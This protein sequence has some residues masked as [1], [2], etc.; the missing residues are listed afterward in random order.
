MLPTL[1]ALRLRIKGLY[2]SQSCGQS[3]LF[4]IRAAG[5]P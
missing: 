1:P 3:V 2:H 4:S 5:R